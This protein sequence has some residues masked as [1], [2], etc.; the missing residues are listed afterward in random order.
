MC[1][2][3]KITFVICIYLKKIAQMKN[4]I[5]VLIFT[6]FTFYCSAQE[7]KISLQ[8]DEKISK[9]VE[10]YK[11]SDEDVEEYQ[12]QIFNGMFNLANQKKTSFEVDFPSWKVKIVHIDVDYR[13]RITDIKSALEAQ[14]K[15]NE[16][17]IKYPAAIIIAPK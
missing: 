1:T 4:T 3:K 6:L 15:Y 10:I 17:R 2:L 14:R 8:Q 16:V 12:I 5:N 11:S 13:V 9:L 7:G